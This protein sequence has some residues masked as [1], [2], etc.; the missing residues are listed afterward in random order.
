MVCAG[1]RFLNGRALYE[2][3]IR[4]LEL[5]VKRKVSDKL[6]DPEHRGINIRLF[7]PNGHYF[8]Y[9]VNF[10]II[11]YFFTQLMSALNAAVQIDKNR[12]AHLRIEISQKTNVRTQII[13]FLTGFSIQKITILNRITANKK[14]DVC[15]ERKSATLYI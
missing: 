12:T 1:V 15:T 5:I 14:I 7:R 8:G 2:N 10:S 4:N 13:V 3:S 11:F 6:S 9:Y